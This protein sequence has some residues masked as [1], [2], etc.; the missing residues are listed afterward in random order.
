MQ[1]YNTINL[2]ACKDVV[3]NKVKE[4]ENTVVIEA[5]TKSLESCPYCGSKHIWVHDHRT[6]KIKD[7][8]MHGKKMH[9]KLKKN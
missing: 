1:E 9:N 6:Q 7:T 5:R 2:L 8:Q 4:S 3:V